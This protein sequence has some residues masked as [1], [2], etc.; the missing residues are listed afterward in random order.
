MNKQQSIIDATFEIA[1]LIR[2]PQYRD[3]F[4]NMSQDEFGEWVRKQLSESCNIELEPVGSSWGVIKNTQEKAVAEEAKKEAAW[5]DWM[6]LVELG[7]QS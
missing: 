7:I 6:N 5:N 4:G 1:F 2:D 3:H